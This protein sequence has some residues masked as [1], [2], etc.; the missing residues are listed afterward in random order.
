MYFASRKPNSIA[1]PVDVHTWLRKLQPRKIIAIT[2]A[3]R[4]CMRVVASRVKEHGPSFGRIEIKDYEV[5]SRLLAVALWSG[6]VGSIVSEVP[7]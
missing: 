1:K 2:L 7:L 5:A 3:Q 6:R 4:C